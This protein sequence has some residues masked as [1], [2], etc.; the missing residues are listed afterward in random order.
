MKKED[1]KAL[2]IDLRNNT[3][4][5]VKSA[6]EIMDDI[7]PEGN[8][9]GMR[10]KDGTREEFKGT[11][12]QKL[13]LPYVVLVNEYT[14]SASEIFAAGVQDFG[15]AEL[16]GTKTYGK[17]ITQ[18]VVK[19]DDGSAVKYTDAELYSPNGNVWHKKGLEPDVEAQLPEDATEDTQLEAALEVLY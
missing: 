1:A 12:P 15:A 5:V 18:K 13:D 4:G 7:L 8:F 3:G 2:V 10:F 11:S 17:G 19:L 9:G 14:A 16:V 6:L